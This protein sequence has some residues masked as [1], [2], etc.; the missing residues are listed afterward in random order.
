MRT[1]AAQAAGVELLP[2]LELLLGPLKASPMPAS[3]AAPALPLTPQFSEL[4][5]CSSSSS[6]STASSAASEICP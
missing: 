1:A 6:A 4:L 3:R 2:E 5:L